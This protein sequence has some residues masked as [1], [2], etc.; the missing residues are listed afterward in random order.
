MSVSDIWAL[1]PITFEGNRLLLPLD[2]VCKRLELMAV[3]SAAQVLHNNSRNTVGQLVKY[4]S[5]VDMS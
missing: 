2:G 1:L 5:C 4:Y 3:V